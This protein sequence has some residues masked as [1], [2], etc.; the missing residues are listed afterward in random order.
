MDWERASAEIYQ[1][2]TDKCQDN[3]WLKRG[4]IMF[5]DDPCAEADYDYCFCVANA[6]DDLAHFFEH[7]NWAIRQ[8]ITYGDLAFIN[9]V[10]GGDEW[11]T[12]KRFDTQWLAFESVTFSPMIKRGEFSR[13]INRLEKA[14]E[15]QCRTLSY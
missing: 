4:G 13:Y 2:L 10:N 15:E 3:M 6:I 9:Q 5:E 1:Q 12:L 14:T 7:G 11:W 8:G